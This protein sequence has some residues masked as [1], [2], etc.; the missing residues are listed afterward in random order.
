MN[1]VRLHRVRCPAKINLGLQIVGRRA[2]GYHELRTVFQAIDLWDDLIARPARRLSLVCDDPTIPV[3]ESNL[4]LR[5]ARL[6]QQECGVARGAR[7]ALAKRIPA[8]GGLGG[9]SSNA[10]G[11]LHVLSRLWGLTVAP[12]RCRELARVLGADVPF[13][14]DG[15]TALA[16]G[17]GDLIEPIPPARALPLVLGLPPFGVPTPEA[18]RRYAGSPRSALTGIV[19]DVSLSRL[20]ALKLPGGNDF[21]VGVNDLEPAV[22]A[23]WPE[24]ARF[25]ESLKRCGAHGAMLSGSGS[26]VFG[27][28]AE[29]RSARAAAER[30]AGGYIGWR[31]EVSRLIRTGLDHGGAPGDGCG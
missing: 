29:E 1:E 14:L 19:N 3:G 12:A 21:A 7:L 25:R 6:L 28:F 31:I 18:F 10:A 26:T 22:F 5:A 27:L 30:L 2:D 13:F 9:G 17:R 15:G 8:G 23:G 20:L 24:L 16:R 11:A 4:V